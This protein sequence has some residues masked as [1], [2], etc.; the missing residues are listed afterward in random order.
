MTDVQK[1]MD[2]EEFDEVLLQARKISFAMEGHVFIVPCYYPMHRWKLYEDSYPRFAILL[3]GKTIPKGVLYRVN[4]DGS[5]H[6]VK[7]ESS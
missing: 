3:S 4:Y 5:V 2:S 7:D 6:E 1:F